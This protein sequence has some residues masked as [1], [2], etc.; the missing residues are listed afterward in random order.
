MLVTNQNGRLGITSNGAD[1]LKDVPAIKNIH[2]LPLRH[3][4]DMAAVQSVEQ[5]LNIVFPQYYLDFIKACGGFDAGLDFIYPSAMGKEFR[6]VLLK[7]IYQGRPWQLHVE[8]LL[9]PDEPGFISDISEMQC[10]LEGEMPSEDNL[11][12]LVPIFVDNGNMFICLDF[13]ESATEPS[14]VFVN[15]ADELAIYPIA[16]SFFDLLKML[17]YDMD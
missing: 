13:R 6:R 3:E 11:I 17:T 14:V 15:V 1:L 5:S 8:A 7:F 9:S 4:L 12:K 16:A 2:W 10:F